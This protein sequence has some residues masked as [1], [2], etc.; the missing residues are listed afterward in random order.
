M[1]EDGPEVAGVGVA[2]LLSCAAEGLTR[3]RSGPNRSICW[4]SCELERVG[5]SADAGEKVALCVL[6][7]FIRFDFGYAAGV[8]DAGRNVPML[9][10]LAQPSCSLR[11]KFV[12]VVHQEYRAAGAIT[13][14]SARKSIG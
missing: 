3:A 7:E 5:P 4:P 10:Q 9:D 8:H 14:F 13:D 11:V 1:P 12:V 6:G 2:E